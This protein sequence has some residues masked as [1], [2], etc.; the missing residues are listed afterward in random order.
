MWTLHVR[1]KF[2]VCLAVALASSTLPPL[3]ASAT[4]QYQLVSLV[5]NE[6]DL[7]HRIPKADHLDPQLANAWGLA[8]GATSPF[9]IADEYTGFSTLYTADGTK[10][11]LVV[12]VNNAPGDPLPPGSPTGIVANP[13]TGF[14]ISQGGV[15][16]P[17]RFIF[18]TLDGTIAGWNPQVDPLDTVIALDNSSKGAA[19][20][21]LDIQVADAGTFIYAAN[22]AANRIEKYDSNFSLVATFSDPSIPPP[23]GVYGVSVLQGQVYVTYTTVFPGKPGDGIVAVF[24]ASGN[25]RTLIGIKPNGP[26]NIPWGMAIAPADFG[27]FSNALLIGNVQ[28]GRI[29]AFDPNSGDFLGTLSHKNGKPIEIPG[30]WGL[31]FGGGSPNNGNTNELFITAGPDTYTG[32]LFGKIVVADDSQ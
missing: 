22:A 21:G 10:Q 31:K 32:G 17:A 2:S 23:F 11:S 28:D 20:T 3:V 27:K 29:N 18:A 13:T 1:H 16:G 9:W 15:S 25:P 8:Y 14:M 26:L 7:G 12:T 5:A 19:Y 6:T 24:D 30:L 4:A